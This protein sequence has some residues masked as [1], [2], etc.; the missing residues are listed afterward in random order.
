MHPCHLSE[1][2]STR[3][4]TFTARFPQLSVSKV[5]D[6]ESLLSQTYPIRN[7]SRLGSTRAVTEVPDPESLH[8]LRRNPVI[9]SDKETARVLRRKDFRKTRDH[10]RQ[11]PPDPLPAA[12]CP[13][14][15][16]Y[17]PFPHF[18][19]LRLFHSVSHP[20]RVCTRPDPGKRILQY[21]V[22]LYGPDPERHTPVPSPLFLLCVLPAV[23]RLPCF[24][25]CGAAVY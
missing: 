19:V 22:R 11:K 18:C 14:R 4:G 7:P 20:I 21:S 1:L 15:P 17:G 23:V 5:P 13:L 8:S 3:K 2:K 12:P 16:L 24:S 9:I 6:P 25:L 10:F